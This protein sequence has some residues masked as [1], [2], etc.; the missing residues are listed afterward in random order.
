M[1][2]RKI[3]GIWESTILISVVLAG[4]LAMLSPSE[5]RPMQLNARVSMGYNFATVHCPCPVAAIT[6]LTKPTRKIQ[7]QNPTIFMRTRFDF[8]L[9]TCPLNRLNY[10]KLQYLRIPCMMAV[11]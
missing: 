9:W 2:Y 7:L 6:Q 1:T 8:C 4:A 11:P 3:E 5:V 10:N